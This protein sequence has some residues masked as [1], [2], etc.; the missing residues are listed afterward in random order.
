MERRKKSPGTDGGERRFD[1]SP[2]EVYYPRL[3]MQD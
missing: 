1:Q 3:E 2:I